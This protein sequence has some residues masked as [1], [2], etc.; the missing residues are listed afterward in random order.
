MDAK[1]TSSPERHPATAAVWAWLE[2]AE[3][4]A[5]THATREKIRKSLEEL[6]A[7]FIAWDKAREGCRV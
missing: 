6:D 3:K 2:S 7:T 5:I 4:P 1:P